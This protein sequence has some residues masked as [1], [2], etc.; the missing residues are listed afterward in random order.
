MT[1]ENPKRYVEGIWDWSV[2]D[3]CFGDTKIKPQDI[4]GSTER[5]GNFLHL[6]AKSVNAEI[7]SG[8]EIYWRNRIKS[9]RDTVIFIW[10]DA[11]TKTV[12]KIRVMS[13]WEDKT[14][15]P[16]NL[17]MFREKVAAWFRWADKNPSE[18][19]SRIITIELVE[20]V[21]MAIQRISNLE[22][23]ML[24]LLNETTSVKPIKKKIEY[25]KGNVIYAN[26]ELFPLKQ[27][28]K[29]NEDDDFPAF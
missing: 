23:L 9:G 20:M 5:K 15:D 14:Y 7:K 26:K 28:A 27:D 3:G 17:E 2:L 11:K 8:Q 18:S 24:Q 13:A 19:S 25:S 6:E 4:D 16:S 1:I 29:K 22:G 21:K 12:E 10:G